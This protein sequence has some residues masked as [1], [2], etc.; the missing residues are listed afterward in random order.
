MK[1]TRPF[2]SF[3]AIAV[4]FAFF[5]GASAAPVSP[6]GEAYYTVYAATKVGGPYAAVKS[7]KADDDGLKTIAI[8]ATAPVRFVRVGVGDAQISSGTE[9]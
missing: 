9:L 2:R 1:S 5:S 4:L 8:P 6:D 3:A 7:E